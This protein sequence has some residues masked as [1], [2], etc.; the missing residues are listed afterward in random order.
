MKWFSVTRALFIGLN[1]SGLS[2]FWLP[3][4][5]IT[6][7]QN[8]LSWAVFYLPFV[9]RSGKVPLGYCRFITA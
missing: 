9:C 8:R 5:Y 7:T 4:R 1:D 2:N 3:Y 6:I